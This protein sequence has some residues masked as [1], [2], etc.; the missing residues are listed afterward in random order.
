MRNLIRASFVRYLKS[1]LTWIIAGIMLI[2][3]FLYGIQSVVEGNDSFPEL[4][5]DD[6]TFLIPAALGAIVV[7]LT[8]GREFADHTVRNKII[9]GSTKPQIYLS[10]AITAAAVMSFYALLVTVPLFALAHKGFALLPEGTVPKL[11]VIFVLLFPAAGIITV[12]ITC[13]TA[14]RTAAV[15]VTGGVLF[16][17][18][19]GGYLLHN[20]IINSYEKTNITHE[21]KYVS[22]EEGN[23]GV[24]AVEKEEPNRQYLPDSTRHLYRTLGSLNPG[25][26]LVEG[27]MYTQYQDGALMRGLTEEAM[28]EPSWQRYWAKRERR[29]KEDTDF[30]PIEI[31]MQCGLIVLLLGAGAFSFRLRDLK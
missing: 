5:L 11:F 28:E 26:T 30:L 14:Q 9:T 13:L 12:L 8:V 21:M 31:L 27:V 1:P 18:Y 17:M 16:G 10:E 4:M 2:A 15:I 6:V 19:L 7:V 20:R 23:G 22:D 3:G 24:T 25:Y 29:Q